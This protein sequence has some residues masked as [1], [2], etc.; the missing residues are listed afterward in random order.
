MKI[1]I[2]TYWQSKDN[3]GQQLQCWALQK[4]LIE[5]GHEPFLIRYDFAN[6]SIGKSLINKIKNKRIYKILKTIAK[7]RLISHSVVDR[8]FDSFRKSKLK[9]SNHYYSTLEELQKKP[10]SADA[11]ICGSDQ[12]WSQLLNV[13]Q[14][15]VFYLNFGK[16][17]IKRIAYAPSFAIKE[18]P[19]ELRN[20]LKENLAR[21]D[22]LSCREHVGVD[23]CASVGFRSELVVD[24]TLLLDRE[25]YEVEDIPKEKK[26]AYVYSLNISSP[27]EIRFHELKKL[28]QKSSIPCLATASTGYFAAS[29]MLDGAEYK[30]AT[31]EEW[32]GLI[33]NAN[34]VITPSFHGIVFCLIF[35]TPF[36]YIPLKG[37][38][39]GGNNRVLDLLSR[40]DLT[41][42][43]LD[44]S[45]TYDILI[46]EEIDWDKTNTLLAEMKKSSLFFL[47][48]A[49][50]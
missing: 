49:L 5:M 16:K 1:G 45:T 31:I 43:I 21:F 48:N 46:N 44:D 27:D 3:Y 20:R 25:S 12:I 18:Y 50:K 11:Y 8:K 9:F 28:L 4:K 36:I 24:P 42:R 39:S 23:I 47:N 38:H 40:L 33:K 14:N 13:R 2:I 30:Y 41:S 32:L 6:R 26:Y 22:F 19:T 7:E 35:N 17:D 37:E 34:F 29:E 15:E 10:P